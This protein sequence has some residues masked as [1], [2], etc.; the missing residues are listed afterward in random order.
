ML[1]PIPGGDKASVTIPGQ[2]VNLLWDEAT[3]AMTSWTISV[4]GKSYGPYS[5][6]QMS[7]FAREGRLIAGS[8]VSRAGENG[9]R[10]AAEDAELAP[11]LSPPRNAAQAVAEAL[12]V[13]RAA[14][15]ADAVDEAQPGPS[16]MLVLTDMKSRSIDG[17][18]RELSK[19]GTVCAVLPQAWLLSTEATANTVRNLL[20]QQLGKLDI[21]MVIDAGRDKSAWFNFGPE[22]DVR[23]RRFWAKR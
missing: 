6:E 23:I 3:R 17:V 5:P 14:E 11:L 7:E 16:H 22:M 21:L 12:P 4:A 10:R 15:R 8:L 20:V 13:S 1:I 9:F 18:E 19:L 2:I